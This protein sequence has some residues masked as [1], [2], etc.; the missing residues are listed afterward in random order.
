[1]GLF[2]FLNRATGRRALEPVATAYSADVICAP[3]SGTAVQLSETSDP[4]FSSGAM[5]PGIAISPI[6]EVVYAPIPGTVTAAMPHAVGITGDN[7]AEVLVHVGVDTVTMG[8]N[9]LACL[10]SQGERIKAGQ[11]ITRFSKEKIAAANK[12]DTVFTIVVNGE[13]YGKVTPVPNGPLMAGDVAVRL[14]H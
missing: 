13:N 9:G 8:G 2:D 11:P 12:D 14:S 1:M 5:G 4:A 7:G 3:V 10:V 6:D